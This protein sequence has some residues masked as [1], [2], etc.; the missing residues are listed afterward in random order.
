MRK[1]SLYMLAGLAVAIGA[2]GQAVA[3]KKAVGNLQRVIIIR[4]GE[5]PDQGDNLSCQGLNRALALPAVLY[6]KI[7]LPSAIFVPSM[8]MGK[9]TDVARMYQTIV[10]FV[11]R[12]NLHI[13]TK[14]DVGD[15]E[16]LAA[17]VH[18]HDGTVLIVWE[19]KAAGKILKALGLP[20][21]EKWPDED[22][23]T[24]WVVT[25]KNGVPTLTKDAEGIRP[26]ANC[27]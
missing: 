16:G 13:N 9:S 6:R 25:Y 19:H 26:G 27:P 8:N 15:A 4:H 2:I 18:K 12:Y 20:G 17:A 14:Y 22:F 1:I 5:K 23:D 7:G 11:I 21:K 10:P 3:Q 24:I